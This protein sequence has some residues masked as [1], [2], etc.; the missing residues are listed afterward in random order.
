MIIMYNINFNNVIYIVAYSPSTH[1]YSNK[2]KKQY[3]D[4]SWMLFVWIKEDRK[5]SKKEG[6]FHSK[7][8][9]QIIICNVY[10]IYMPICVL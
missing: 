1:F 6:T 4:Y 7:C 3:F 5:I 10:G 9:Q 8:T 2:K